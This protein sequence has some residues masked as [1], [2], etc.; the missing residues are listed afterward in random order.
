VSYFSYA[1]PCQPVVRCQTAR[2][3]P[4]SLSGVHN[5]V[6]HMV[7][8]CANKLFYD[9][10]PNPICEA[11]TLILNQYGATIPFMHR[12]QSFHSLGLAPIKIHQFSILHLKCLIT[13]ISKFI[14]YNNTKFNV[15]K[16]LLRYLGA[17]KEPGFQVPNCVYRFISMYK[18]FYVDHYMLSNM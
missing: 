3:V 18:S 1:E 11:T 15:Y 12:S 4:P 17:S 7:M 6:Q 5:L 2:Q 14:Q 9:T 10:A 16:H 13:T 8:G